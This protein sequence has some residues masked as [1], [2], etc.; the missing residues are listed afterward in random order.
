[1]TLGH[2]D[3]VAG[4]SAKWMSIRRRTSGMQDL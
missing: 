3:R 4:R 1:M 2:T